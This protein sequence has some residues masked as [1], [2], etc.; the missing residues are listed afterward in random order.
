MSDIAVYGAGGFGRETALMIQ[1]IAQSGEDWNLVGFFDDGIKTG[2]LVDSLPVLGGMNELNEYPTPLSVA[3]AIADPQ[4]RQGCVQRI[5]NKGIRFPILIHPSAGAGSTM[6]V[7]ERGV[8]ITAGVILTT[9]IRIGEFAIVNLGATI[10]HDASIGNFSSIMPQCSI[11]GNVAIGSGTFVGAG[12]RII[13]GVSMGSN[14]VVGAGAVVT[15]SFP[16]GSKVVGIPARPI[17]TTS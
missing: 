5:T 9:G 1:Q 12:A 8:L 14:C 17:D 6:N 10:G 7:L 15:K 11:S 13:Q 3:M 2:S 16:D 4:V